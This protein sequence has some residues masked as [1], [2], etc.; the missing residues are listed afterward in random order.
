MIR[1]I[2]FFL[3][4]GC[5]C[6]NA[7]GQSTAKPDAATESKVAAIKARYKKVNESKLKANSITWNNE[8]L[9]DCPPVMAGTI[10]FYSLNNEVVKVVNNG[11]ED[12]GEWKEE[13]YFSN[14]KLFFIYQNNAY[15]GAAKP[16][17]YKYQNR[18]YID[19]DKVIKAIESK[20]K[21]NE[22]T[23]TALIQTANRLYKTKTK[24]QVARIMSCP[25][26]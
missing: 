25:E 17:E 9:S 21:A 12:H 5:L 2:S 11:G 19:N 10:I 3:L 24:E 26:Q 8:K 13:Y 23:I 18:Y 6:T 20:D 4:L 1:Q 16:T 22:E 14:G 15:G 7:M